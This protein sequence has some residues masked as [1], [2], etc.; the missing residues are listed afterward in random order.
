MDDIL[1]Q[2]SLCGLFGP[3]NSRVVKSWNFGCDQT[4][5]SDF[6]EN[7]MYKERVDHIINVFLKDSS[8]K[9]SKFRDFVEA[10]DSD[11][12]SVDS[13]LSWETTVYAKQNNNIEFKE[14]QDLARID[15]TLS[16]VGDSTAPNTYTSMCMHADPGDTP[17]EIHNSNSDLSS[18]LD[19]FGDKMKKLGY[20]C[21]RGEWIKLDGEIAIPKVYMNVRVLIGGKLRLRSGDA[22]NPPI[23]SY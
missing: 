22:F 11:V 6:K 13:S 14:D 2:Y 4:L 18:L 16:V 12:E 23:I 20:R 5:K 15:Y 10:N 7:S 1:Q 8:Y 19:I 3:Q 21:I 17:E 9:F